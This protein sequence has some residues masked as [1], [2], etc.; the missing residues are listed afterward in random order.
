MPGLIQSCGCDKEAATDDELRELL[1]GVFD[2][3]E[4]GTL[5]PMVGCG[6]RL[7]TWA[8]V[9]VCVCVLTEAGPDPSGQQLS[10]G[11]AHPRCRQ[12]VAHARCPRLCGAA[13]A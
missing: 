3:I 11:S 12:A 4:A 1:V 6:A 8:C 13:G 5:K 10:V 2:G 9:C 7:H